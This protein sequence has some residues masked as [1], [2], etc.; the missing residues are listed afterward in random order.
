MRRRTRGAAAVV[1][2]TAVRRR[3]L[4]GLGTV[5][6]AG[7]LACAGLAG[8]APRPSGTVT[9]A[10]PAAGDEVATTAATGAGAYTRADM[11]RPSGSADEWLD[12]GGIAASGAAAVPVSSGAYTRSDMPRPSGSA[13]EWLDVEGALQAAGGTAAGSGAYT[14]TDMPRPSGSAGEWLD[15]A[16]VA[17]GADAGSSSAA[18]PGTTNLPAVSGA[19]AQ[20][21]TE[22]EVVLEEAWTPEVDC[23]SCHADE[24]ASFGDEAAFAY[25]HAALA[26]TDCHT[27][28]E[29]LAQAHEGATS[30]AAK[31]AALSATGV[32]DELCL[33]CH[34][35]ETLVAATQDCAMLTDLNGTVVNPHDIPDVADHA[36]VTC[37][38]CHEMHGETSDMERTVDRVC[39]SCHHAE[40]YEC[41]TCHA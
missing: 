1:R 5:L 9:E 2:S 25:E 21:N 33:S 39:A 38:R 8:A 7:A 34:D 6:L 32:S 20:Q 24:V 35:R 26:C 40:V 23:A 31:L 15:V 16:D 22:P 29:T 13:A 18:L 10:V 36:E 4:V 14:R 19:G 12:A 27:D 41:Y 30:T 3:A 37:V 28:T 17:D 11:P